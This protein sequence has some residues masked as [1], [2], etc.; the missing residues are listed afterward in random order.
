[1][2][3]L[4]WNCRGLAKPPAV[5]FL[6][7]INK[8]Y[9][10]NIIFLSETLVKRNRIERVR[11]ILGFGACFAVDAQGHGGGLALF[12]K[13]EGGVVI[14]GSSQN[15]ID[16][17]VSNEQ[18]G[19]WRY[20]GFYGY[21]ERERRAASWDLIRNLTH[22]SALPWCIIGD[23][24]DMISVGEKRGGRSHPR[25]LLEGFRNTLEDCNL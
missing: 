1:M 21:P 2:S 11:K 25:H 7:E 14:T 19:K 18:V 4:A 6:K 13:N 20:T 15:F 9:R 17:E 10:P 12:W 5:R 24:N 3:L 16:F 8:Q 22:K 23:F